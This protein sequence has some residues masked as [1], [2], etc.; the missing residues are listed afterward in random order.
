MPHAQRLWI[1]LA[2]GLSHWALMAAIQTGCFC[3]YLLPAGAAASDA[4]R[5]LSSIPLIQAQNLGVAALLAALAWLLSFNRFTVWLAPLLQLAMAALAL[6]DQLFYKIFFDHLRPSLFEMGRNVNAGVA[7][8]SLFRETDAVFFAAAAIAI[9]G[10]IW[11]VAAI[12]RRPRRPS[13]WRFWGVAG[14]LLFVAGLPAFASARYCHL[15]EHPAV[16]AARD[17]MAG[18]LTAQLRGRQH[19]G[20]ARGRREIA[21]VDRDE[22]LA[23]LGA[24]ARAGGPPNVLLIVLE[25]V[26]ARNL[27]GPDG[28][29]SA[30]HAPNLARL[31][32]RG[33]IFNSIYA[34]YPATVRSHVSIHTGGRQATQGDLRELEAWYQGPMLGRAMRD[35]GY[36]TALFSSQRLDVE[37]CDVFLRQGQYGLFQDFETDL[38]AKFPENSIHS[39][40]AREEYTLGLM[41]SWL[42]KVRGAGKPFYL[43]Y[44]TVATHHPYGAPAGYASPFTGGTPQAQYWNAMHY[45]DRAVGALLASL[46]A[47]GLLDNTLIAITGDH[48]EAFGDVHAMNFLHKNFLYEENVREFL[49]L[50]DPRWKLREPIRSSRIASNGGVMPTLLAYLGAPDPSLPGPDLLAESFESKPVFFYKTAMPEQWGLRD[51]QWKYVGEIRTGKAELYDLADDPLEQRNLAPENR[52]RVERYAAMCEE[53]FVR[54]DAEYAARLKDY[55]PVGGRAL[56]PEDYRVPG[57]KIQAVGFRGGGAFTEA[58][59][60]PKGVSPVVWDSWI[61]DG[62]PRH[63][64]WVWASPSGVERSSEIDLRD[65]WSSTYSTFPGEIPMEAGKWRVQLWFE[66]KLR[67]TSEFIAP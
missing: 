55:R 65:D 28:L 11:I 36:S 61:P 26:G 45:T 29:P 35:L 23:A 60:I 57:P 7:S 39:W 37:D 24:S 20:D 56:L 33:V 2:A 64:R 66:G 38:A 15:N 12:L 3:A 62:N 52:A 31:A 42:D 53:W 13:P 58:P 51:G 19:S 16:A 9:A 10:E 54:S 48:G 17:W 41:D 21:A 49:L 32:Q 27:L 18:S 44:M 63:A 59:R 50:S 43:E 67:F 8:S 47:K 25:S 40:G 5:H 34:P 46:E 4:L 22:R 1:A 6:S 14:A 30:I